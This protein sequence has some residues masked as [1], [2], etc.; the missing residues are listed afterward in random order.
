M[1]ELKYYTLIRYIQISLAFA[2]AIWIS[3]FFNLERSYWIPMTV[4]IMFGPFEEGT[5]AI[6]V[7]ERMLGTLIGLLFGILLV[8]LLQFSELLLYVLPLI[9]FFV[10][11]F[12]IS[13]YVI[14]CAFIT[15]M[16]IFIFAMINPQDTS[17]LQFGFDRMID[18][19]IAG[20]I[21]IGFEV[22][23]RPAKL[24]AQTI[25]ISIEDLLKAYSA[26]LA[27]LLESLAKDEKISF[28][29]VNR[30]NESIMQ[31]QKQIDLSKYRFYKAS[32]SQKKLDRIQNSLH[33][34][35][36]E[37]SVIHYLA[38]FYHDQLKRLYNKN[39]QIFQ[40]LIHCYKTE[41]ITGQPLKEI[42]DVGLLVYDK[43][44]QSEVMLIESIS[45]IHRLFL[46][47]FSCSIDQ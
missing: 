14:A 23:F 6:R 12:I 41:S 44:Q 31:F 32:F 1:S 19:V 33:E 42:I 3:L 43:N 38:K 28:E 24:T 36:V 37:L 4:M 15:I 2:F 13:N 46:T 11:Y 20:I 18:T 45:K 26:H 16:V 17:P 27:H 47:V 34:I 35:R 40:S 30:F 9:I 5:V 29:H 7:K 8:S 25:K 10:A 21:C 39:R 22:M